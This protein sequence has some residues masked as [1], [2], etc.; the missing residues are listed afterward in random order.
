[1]LWVCKQDG[2]RYAVGLPGCPECGSTEYREEGAESDVPTYDGD[3]VPDGTADEVRAWVG[4]NPERAAL[5]LEAE[6]ARE[7]PRS[8][9]VDQLAKLTSQEV[10]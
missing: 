2:V 5:A 4:D 3:Q 7:K 10:K 8:T 1:M 9:L 6:Q